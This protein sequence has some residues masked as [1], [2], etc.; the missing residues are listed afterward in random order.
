MFRISLTVADAR[1][2]TERRLAQRGRASDTLA[3]PQRR[4]RG[5]WR[6]AI[7][8]GFPRLRR[9]RQEPVNEA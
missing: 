3:V 1:L 5:C 4:F 9:R 8:Y 6:M 7:T 2:T